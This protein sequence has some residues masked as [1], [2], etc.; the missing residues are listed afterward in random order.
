MTAGTLLQVTAQPHAGPSAQ[1]L[2]PAGAAWQGVSETA[3][4]LVPTPLD[5]QPSAYVRSSW[6]GRPYGTLATAGVSAVV[7]GGA[8][9]IRL[10]WSAAEPRQAI[11]DN[12]TYADACAALF[13]LDGRE[14]ELSAM[15]D[16]RHPVQAW[17]WRAGTALPFVITA[18]GLGTTTR[19]P[20]HPVSV[21]AAWENGSW[22]V[23]FRRDLNEQGVPLAAGRSV[24]MG[25]AVWSGAN[26]E[27]AG[28]KAHTPDWLT[29][30]LPK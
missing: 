20:N 23:V 24:P 8:L 4:S 16:E 1:L 9:Y 30:E 12:N 13:P 25:V 2:A 5:A 15:G 27:R 11:T 3:V 17:H 6:A 21:G 29:L 18:T 22:S 19:I 7:S 10:R 26:N 28:I 14:A